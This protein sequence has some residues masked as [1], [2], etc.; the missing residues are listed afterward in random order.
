MYQDYKNTLSENDDCCHYEEYIPQ[1]N[2]DDEFSNQQSCV[3]LDELSNCPINFSHSKRWKIHFPRFVLK[4]LIVQYNYEYF[5][6]SNENC[7]DYNSKN[8]NDQL[9][10]KEYPSGNMKSEKFPLFFCGGG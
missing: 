10:L 4:Q 6:N 9:K 8:I 7:N 2:D 3:P 1:E 5:S